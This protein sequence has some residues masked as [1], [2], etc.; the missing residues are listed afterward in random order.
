MTGSAERTD[1]ELPAAVAAGDGAPFATFD[2][3]HLPTVVGFILRETGDRGATADL[4]AEVSAATFLVARRFRARGAGSAR[5]WVLGIARSKILES[6]RRG[7]V[8][9][10][11]RRRV[12]FE[13]EV[14]ATARP[15]DGA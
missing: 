2:R 15:T 14:C 1:G 4:T 11:A 9:D 8:E 6:R 3:R 13:P 5:P 12:A 7:R 10:R